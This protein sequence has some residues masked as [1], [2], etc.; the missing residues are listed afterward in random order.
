[1]KEKQAADVAMKLLVPS[2][3]TFTHR[4]IYAAQNYNIHPALH[5]FLAVSS[6]KRI[7]IQTTLSMH[8]AYYMTVCVSGYF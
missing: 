2:M 8:L 3:L 1:M 5:N 4:C 7:T 6:A